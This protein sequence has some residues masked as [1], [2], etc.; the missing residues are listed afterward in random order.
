MKKLI[1]IPMLFCFFMLNVASMCSDDDN[2]NSS[3]TDPSLVVNT[4]NQGTWRVSSFID[5]GANETSHF[6]GYNFTFGNGNVLTATNGVNTYAGT[7][8]V[9]A[10]DDDDDN[11]GGDLDFNIAFA[12]PA[13]FNELSEDWNI[14]T[15][16]SNTVALVHTSNG[17][18]GTDALVLTK[19]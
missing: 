5:S 1:L 14:V 8:S 13:E 12:N 3:S 15:Y 16:S 6:A 19:N 2:D 4:I 11:P 18:G 9:T 7:W 10:D 17:G